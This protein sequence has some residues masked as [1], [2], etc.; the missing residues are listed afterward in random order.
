MQLKI[1]TTEAAHIV[2][3]KYNVKFTEVSINPD[4]SVET[5]DVGFLESMNGE[6]KLQAIKLIRYYTD[7]SLK[8]AKEFID[9]FYQKYHR[10]RNLRS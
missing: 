10:I 4:L 2:A 1:N 5:P 9:E 7:C 8:E 6:S 3:E